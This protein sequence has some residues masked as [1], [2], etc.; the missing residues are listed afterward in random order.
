MAKNFDDFKRMYI[1][2]D[3]D[4]SS[5]RIH[6]NLDSLRR[7]LADDEEDV[8]AIGRAALDEVVALL[9]EYHKWVNS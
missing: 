1:N 8:A 2:G 7:S 3:F 5:E 6:E 9:E 4:G